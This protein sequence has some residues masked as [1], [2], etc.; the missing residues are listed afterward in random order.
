MAH[1]LGLDHNSRHCFTG[2]DDHG[3]LS[4]VTY[5]SSTTSYAPRARAKAM[6]AWLARGPLLFC[7]DVEFVPSLADR[8]QRSSN[9]MELEDTLPGIRPP[10]LLEVILGPQQLQQLPLR[11]GSELNW[12]ARCRTNTQ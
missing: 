5:N 6:I 7:Q 4:T 1:E 2:N 8:E 11:G 10:G 9:L 12:Y 3:L